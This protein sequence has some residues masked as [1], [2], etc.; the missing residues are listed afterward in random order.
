MSSFE[1]PTGSH[2]DAALSSTVLNAPVSV[3]QIL[4]V[5]SP[6]RAWARP[7]PLARYQNHAWGVSI[8]FQPP[9]TDSS[10]AQGAASPPGAAGGV[11]V[12]RVRGWM[13]AWPARDRPRALLV[14]RLEEER[15]DGGPVGGRERPVPG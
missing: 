4:R 12:A 3:G 5:N 15:P 14:A 9:E 2:S 1:S 6:D 10:P 8:P 13:R 11:R 7:R